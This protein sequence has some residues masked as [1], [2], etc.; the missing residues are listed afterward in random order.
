MANLSV[1]EPYALMWARTGLWEPWV[2]NDPRPPG[3]S[4]RREIAAVIFS[5]AHLGEVRRPR[6]SNE[7]HISARS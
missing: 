6:E 1:E 3:P 2:G 7:Q 4:A 5:T